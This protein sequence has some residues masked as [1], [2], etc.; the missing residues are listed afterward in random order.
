MSVYAVSGESL[1]SVADAI[2]EKGGTSAQLTYPADFISAINSLDTS[3]GGGG[4][5]SESVIN[6]LPKA[7]NFRDYDGRV[8]YAYTAAEFAQLSALPSN[9][10]HDG[11]IAQGWN[12][13]LSD[14][15]SY[16]SKYGN[17]EVGQ[18]YITDDGKT[19][20]YIRIGELRKSPVM[21]MG[22][23]GSV[24]ID[25]GD[26][27]PT[28][29]LTGTSESTTLWTLPHE[30][31][32]GG[33][34]VITLRVTGKMRLLGENDASKGARLLCGS[35]AKGTEDMCY[36]NA[37]KSINIGENVVLG[38]G[39]FCGLHSLESITV[40]LGTT[41]HSP[42]SCFFECLS[43]KG[44]T[45]PTSCDRIN[46][47]MFSRCYNLESI[48]LP[49]H[50]VSF[51]V[52]VFQSDFSLKYCSVPDNVTKVSNETFYECRILEELSIPDSVSEI[53]SCAFYRCY[54]MKE[55]YFYTTT[56]PT[57]SYTN[58]FDNIPSDCIIYVPS[59]SLEEYKA[60]TNWSTFADRMVGF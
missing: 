17:L 28:A 15:Q 43:L 8:M 12:W 31:A 50:P 22:V 46:R 18:V 52:G 58:A 35:S 13:T 11:L 5:E 21:G 34:F 54:G 59:A 26:N 9:P 37:V 3:G 20:I 53:G 29:T 55:I 36:H 16:V 45:V 1:E 57:L 40:S 44:I 2:R 60:A 56:P 10:S 49:R 41:C 7:V 27:T 24:E 6:V 51:D 39:A 30:Y 19:R 33:D 25:W 48:S 42:S 23:N 4:E 47:T 14:A 38:S 32:A